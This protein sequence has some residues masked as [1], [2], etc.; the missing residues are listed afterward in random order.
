M[1]SRIVGNRDYIHGGYGDQ[2][3]IPAV[4]AVAKHRKL[5]ALVLKSG[6]ALGAVIAE[7]HRREK[8]PL[9]GL[10]ASDVL[11]DFGNLS[12]DVRS[13]DVRQIHSGQSFANPQIDV[14]QGAGFDA[15]Q[16]LVLAWL[17]I[18]YVFVAQNLRTTEFM[19]ANGFHRS[20]RRKSN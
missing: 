17:G 5:R 11:A 3:A 15:D 4:H 14:V 6:H 13:K 7:V 9:P 12:G 1:K 8:H 19:D 10:E 2:F 16:N 20:L 18:R